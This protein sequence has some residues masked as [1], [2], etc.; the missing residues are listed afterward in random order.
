MNKIW[1]I[2]R[3][4]LKSYFVSPVAYI[5]IG[6]FAFITGYFA[7]AFIA[8]SRMAEV[9]PILMNMSFI[10]LFMSPL[11]TMRL[12]S[13]EKKL[14]TIEFLFTSPI[15]ISEI[16][17]GKFIAAA[18]LFCIIIGVALQYPFFIVIY[19][20]PD[21]GPIMTSLLG[22]FLAGLAC[23]AVGLFTSSLSDNQLVSAVVGMIMLLL[24]WIIGWAGSL[25]G[26][27]VGKFFS[28]ISMLTNLENFTK[29]I[30]DAGSL[31]YF[32]ALI[33]FFLYL[34]I[35]RLEWKRW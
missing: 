27:G 15:K 31:I 28:D 18:I 3:R 8:S 4:E 21:M 13:E 25:M 19:G 24:F 33:S 32:I 10:F 20:R 17:I 26:D 22:F 12:L 30:I 2:A 34:T 35:K 9:R 23:L 7:I 5:V 29:G 16:V 1:I 6:L 14:G 11:V